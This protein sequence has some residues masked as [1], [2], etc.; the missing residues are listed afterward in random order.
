M[1]ACDLLTN[2]K[3]WRLMVDQGLGQDGCHGQRR[4][5]VVSDKSTGGG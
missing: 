5:V 1:I 4:L 2:R 3:S